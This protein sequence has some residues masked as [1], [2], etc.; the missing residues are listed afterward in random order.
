[1]KVPKR[2]FPK[3][4]FTGKSIKMGLQ[5]HNQDYRVQLCLLLQ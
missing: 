5:A 3:E 4:S 1:M 2:I